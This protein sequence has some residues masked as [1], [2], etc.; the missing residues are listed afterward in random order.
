MN[1]NSDMVN[2]KQAAKITGLC[3]RTLEWWRCENKKSKNGKKPHPDLKYVQMG[4]KIFYF[5]S[6]IIS[7][8]ERN[9]EGTE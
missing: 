8:I 4:R 6:A 9:T 2:T 7:Y 5:K 1:D 3:Y